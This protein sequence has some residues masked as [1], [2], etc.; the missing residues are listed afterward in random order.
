MAS[1]DTSTAERAGGRLAYGF[2]DLTGSFPYTSGTELGV[3][4]DVW[5]S[6]G[7]T[8]APLINEDRNEVF[9]VLYT[10]GNPLLMVRFS[11]QDTDAISFIWPNSTTSGADELVDWPGS[12]YR[13]GQFVVGST[14]LLEPD[15]GGPGL[16]FY[17]AIPMVDVNERLRYSFRTPHSFVA[18]FQAIRD[19]S[20]RIGQMGPV[21]KLVAP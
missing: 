18:M 9:N 1:R 21:N 5:L 19:G 14:L 7:V 2:T 12:N 10:G 8:Y 20:G 6:P 17:N 16:I 13:A 11:T 4:L 3:I 15:N